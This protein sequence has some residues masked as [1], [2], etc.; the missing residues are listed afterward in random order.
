MTTLIVAFRNLANAPNTV[1]IVDKATEDP[2]ALGW[3]LGRGI[4]EC[5]K[6]VPKPDRRQYSGLLL[7]Y[8][9]ITEGSPDFYLFTSNAHCNY[10][11]QKF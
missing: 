3:R 7:L 1:I 5:V 10:K 6:K 4:S 2:T 8:L 11:M 9:V